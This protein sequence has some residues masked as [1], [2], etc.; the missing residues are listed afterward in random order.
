MNKNTK[1]HT[2][3]CAHTHEE[4]KCK[5]GDTCACHRTGHNCKTIIK[6]GVTLF[7]AL[8]I[9]GSILA[10]ADMMSGFRRTS[11]P[12]TSESSMRAFIKSNPKL[13]AD[14][15]EAYYRAQQKRQAEAQKPKVADSKLIDEIINDK[16]NYSL[17]NPNGKYVI[18]EFFDYQCGWCKRTNE[19]IS[20]AIAEGKAPNIRWI[21]IDTPIFGE[22]SEM[23]SRYVLAA[24]KQGKFAQMHDA[25]SKLKGTIDETALIEAAKAIK[26]DTKKLKTDASSKAIADKLAANKKYTQTL[27]IGGVPMLIVDGMI[28]PG[29]LIGEKLEAAIKASNAKK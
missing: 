21:L 18:I 17:G 8:L 9:S 7:S 14:T 5:S 22:K 16:T 3:A 6:S 27:Q 24:G 28:N 12:V 15:M 11:Q 10:A 20:K 2:R 26:L 23:I 13:I 4:S 29:A 25:V 1:N 19:G